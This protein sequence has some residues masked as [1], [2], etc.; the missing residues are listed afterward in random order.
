MAPPSLD[1]PLPM[2]TAAIASLALLALV[3]P[4]VPAG[5]SPPCSDLAGA[6]A[7]CM[8]DYSHGSRDCSEG[9]SAGWRHT[10]AYAEVYGQ[11]TVLLSGSHYCERWKS[12]KGEGSYSSDRVEVVANTHGD[13]PGSGTQFAWFA[14]D[15]R[16][17][18][19]LSHHDPLIQDFGGE[20]PVLLGPPDA[21]WG[22]LLP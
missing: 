18:I 17:G 5:A 16:G 11:S 9:P 20:T 21:G 10:V 8:Y 19:H 6:G 15:D 2:R 13:L 7:V 22:H 12:D 3:L 1:P 4:A 14:W